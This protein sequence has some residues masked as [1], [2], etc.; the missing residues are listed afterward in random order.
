MTLPQTVFIDRDGDAWQPIGH[1]GA[2]E[3]L[4][5][6]PQPSNPE[7]QGVGESFAWTLPLVQAQFGPLIARSAVSG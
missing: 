1:N 4:L 5:S 2:G 6:C 7:D 3:L